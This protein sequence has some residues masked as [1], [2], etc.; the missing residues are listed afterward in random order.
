MLPPLVPAA[1]Y[2]WF[3]PTTPSA[4]ALAKHGKD[5][6]PGLRAELLLEVV[7]QVAV[8]IELGAEDREPLTTR[9]ACRAVLC[10]RLRVMAI[11]TDIQKMGGINIRICKLSDI[12]TIDIFI[13]SYI[14][15]TY[16]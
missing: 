5:V 6:L 12:H 8:H 9:A 4:L 7:V 1:G 10:Q 16:N 13:K 2:I 15:H 3:Q 11:K 14:R